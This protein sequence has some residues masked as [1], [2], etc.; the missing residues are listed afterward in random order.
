M[1]ETKTSSEQLTREDVVEY[2]NLLREVSSEKGT[3]PLHYQISQESEGIGVWESE[4]KAFMDAYTLKMLFF[5]E[6]WV[7]IC[8]D[9]VAMKLSQLPLRVMQGRMIEEEFV[10]KPVDSH[11]LNDIL[12]QPN[13]YQSY[14]SWMYSLLVDLCLIGNTI[15]WDPAAK[16][17]L[18]GLPAESITINLDNDGGIEE[19]V[20]S[21]FS[22][23][24]GLFRP[25]PVTAFPVEEIIHMRRPNP[26]SLLWGM[27]PFVP[28]RKSVLF[29]R[30]SS[31]YLN[32]FYQKGAIPGF[33]L[34]MDKE[35]NERVAL[36][37][38]RSFENA[39][40]G[41]RNMRRT[42]VLPKGINVKEL[43]H[44]LANQELAE[45]IDRNREN[46]INLLKIPKHELSL[47]EAGSLG[48]EEAKTALKN[49]WYSTL[50]PLSKIVEGDL[51]KHFQMRGILTPDQY[52]EFDKTDVDALKE[53]EAKKAELAEKMLKTHTLNEVRQIVYNLPP[54]EGGDVV[55]GYGEGAAGGAGAPFFFSEMPA[56]FGEPSTQPFSVE[57]AQ[58]ESKV[59][60]E[61][62]EEAEDKSTV[63][64]RLKA[65]KD[66][67]TEHMKSNDNWF[68]RRES[69]IQNSAKTAA[70][71]LERQTMKMFA[72]MAAEIVKTAQRFLK[73]KSWDI[74]AYDV[75]V[76]NIYGLKEKAQERAKLVGRNELRRRL[77]RALD[78]F[79]ERWV[80]ESR[81]TLSSTM[82]VGYN[83]AFEV[84]FNMPSKREIAALRVRGEAARQDAL[85]KRAGRIFTYL[86][87]T[88]IGHVFGTIERG[89]DEGKT[90]QEIAQNLRERFQD[91]SQI[92]SRAMTIARTETLTAVS[93]GQ[94]EAMKDA[95]T[96]VDDLQKM[97]V[98]A[99]DERV[100][101]SHEELHGDIVKYDEPFD[102]NLQFPRDPSG[103]A[104]EV[105]NCRCTWIMV[106]K[107]Q[108]NEIDGDLVAAD[109][110][111]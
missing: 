106:P 64:E 53:D 26:S 90:V 7:Y 50:I 54:V 18:I 40:T 31:D 66:K 84:P 44:T 1:T 110:E 111:V 109:Q 34:E 82:D 2:Q 48:S 19:Y 13:Q 33:A 71:D 36:R 101:S 59:E 46:I 28:G 67:I 107:D 43:A 22:R 56:R 3:D 25:Q 70:H 93:I 41:R 92:Q 91:V 32:S 49:F 58:I 60:G 9:L 10:A 37:L 45:H 52:L 65:Q 85:E 100:R 14:H 98:S 30:Y 27:S 72:D 16:K 89:I 87:E 63:S 57:P 62:D 86:N 35:A 102:N 15:Q 108:M 74:T 29:N 11:E 76:L 79:E 38:L 51:T 81:R 73:E 94:A 4:V 12:E 78:G 39:Y 77:R 97:W 17:G 8:V 69:Q 20:V 6:D 23:D 99:D 47:Q 104:E 55:T 68:D 24:A 103:P 95:A 105:I 61:P 5:S 21:E 96:V 88:T 83:A 80:D 42:L 75:K